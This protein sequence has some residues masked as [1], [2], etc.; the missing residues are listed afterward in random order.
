[1]SVFDG[2]E[3][4]KK[5][6]SAHHRNPDQ[7]APVFHFKRMGRELAMQYLF[8]C[9]LMGEDRSGPTMENFW[10]QAEESGEFPSNRIFRKARAYA[11]KLI[12]GV[13][14]KEGEID[15]LLEKFSWKWDLGRMSAVDRNIMR[16]AIYELKYCPD[17]PPLV[18][19]DEAIEIAKDFS[20]EKSGI[21]INGILNGVKDT[22][23]EDA[24]GV[25]ATPLFSSS[26]SSCA[27]SPE[28]RTGKGRKGR[29]VEEPE[30]RKEQE[31]REEGPA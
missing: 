18:S 9:D 21:F 12:G 14:E 25:S 17:I 2:T 23:P 4:P 1:M 8:Q 30:E 13:Q 16:V 11:E 19:I 22:L 3:G 10:E 20:S 7:H 6:L 24:A 5:N 28:G 26:P 27:S 31:L 15:E 29:G